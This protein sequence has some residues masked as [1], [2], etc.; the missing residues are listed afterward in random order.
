MEVWIDYNSLSPSCLLLTSWLS[1][2]AATFRSAGSHA[3]TGPDSKTCPLTRAGKACGER[4]H[5]AAIGR[6]TWL[7][8]AR[9]WCLFGTSPSLPPHLHH[10]LFHARPQP[11]PLFIS[12]YLSLNLTGALTL[13]L[14]EGLLQAIHSHSFK[15]QRSS[16]VNN[17]R[18]ACD[19]S[20]RATFSVSIL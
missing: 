9:A 13:R 16:D 3:S 4:H 20:L 7:L 11:I 1:T 15:Y 12:Q 2:N 17:R 5:C 14:P 6:R 10:N 19:S 8:G 18:D